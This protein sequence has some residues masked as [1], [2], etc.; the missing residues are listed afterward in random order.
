M[1]LGGSKRRFAP[2]VMTALALVARAAYADDASAPAPAAPADQA[3]P[4]PLERQIPGQPPPVA[5]PA[6]GN[7]NAVPPPQPTTSDMF[8]PVPDRWRIL[9]ALGRRENMFDPYNTNSLKGDKP[10]FGEDWFFS[11]G[12]ISDTLYEPARVPTPVAPQSVNTPGS[13]SV[14]GKYGRSLFSQTALL[15]LDLF[16]GDTA[17]KPPEIELRLTPAFNFNHTA[18]DE[19][20]VIN[21]NPQRG[22]VRDDTFGALQEAFVDYH[23]RNVS[24]RYDFDSIRVGIQPF[25]TDF[26]GF[27]FQD[28][29]LGVRLFGDRQNNLWQYNLAYFRRLEKDT[30]SGL[31]DVSKPLRR[32]DVFI[33]NL[34]RQD[35]PLTGFTSQVT[36]VRNDN[37][38]AG[39]F[40]YDNNGFLVRPLPIGSFTGYNYDV[41]YLGYNGDG[42]FG[43]F[44]LTVSTY[45]QFGHISNN[46]FSPSPLPSPEFVD[47]F[48]FAAE[49]S[50]DFD[51]IRVRGSAL[52]QSG[53][54]NPQ[55]GR[56]TGFDAI[57]ENPQ[58]AGAD[59]SYWIRQGIPLIGGGGVALSQSNGVLADLRSSKNEGQSNFINPG[60]ELLGLGAD[61][62]VLP[63]LRISGNA[64]YL[65]FVTT[66]PLVLLRHQSNIPDEIG[67]DLSVA[68]TYRPLDSQ[69]IVLRLSGA[70]L[71]PGSG[72]NAL[73]QTGNVAP[74]SGG[75]FLYSALFNIILTY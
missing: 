59:S 38:E 65:R 25:S 61:F 13:N 48:F 55:S 33:A 31:N 64:N 6:L 50:I 66:A 67:W 44:N 43:R 8:L 19:R 73:Y 40:Y 12:A 71:V 11:L 47:G 60:L 62:D 72:L 35:M 21:I 34:Y 4:A 37:H 24:E 22:T 17:Y 7:P 74:F 69:N 28:T 42:H 10:I 51:W 41:N 14:F 68:A 23:I 18:V 63:E 5:P 52:Y 20:G 46:E 32:D 29:Q 2:L 54:A 9:D 45:W 16:K 26:R 15:N 53:D 49:P 56:A 1:R 27:L 36:Y 30:N 3:A 58:F 75:H 57:F 39:Q 70:T